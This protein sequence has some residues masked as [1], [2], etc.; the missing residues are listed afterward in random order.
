MGHGRSHVEKSAM[1]EQGPLP[2][3]LHSDPSPLPPPIS[4][5]DSSMLSSARSQRTEEPLDT[6]H[7]GQAPGHRAGEKTGA[8]EGRQQEDIQPTARHPALQCP[9]ATGSSLSQSLKGCQWRRASWA[10][11][12]QRSVLRFCGGHARDTTQRHSAPVT[13]SPVGSLGS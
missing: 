2:G 3:T 5:W 10:P 1:T 9:V 4:C 12:P 11:K 6:V 13:P 8:A 7:T